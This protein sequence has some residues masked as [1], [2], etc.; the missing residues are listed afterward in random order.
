VVRRG[1]YTVAQWLE[2]CVE[3]RGNLR[4]NTRRV[5][6]SHV[7]Q[8]LRRVFDGML[9]KEL[10]VA[11]VERAFARLLGEGMTAATARR[12]FST[13]R[14][15]LNAAVREGLIPR[16][17]AR[18]VKLPRAHQGVLRGHLTRSRGQMRMEAM[19]IVPWHPA[20]RTRASRPAG[21]LTTRI[22]GSLGRNGRG[23]P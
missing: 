17:P 16:S 14:T 21:R 6:K 13:L 3:T 15:A 10:D 12:V 20:C 22:S 19:P 4:H 2:A 7:R 11:R 23:S 1:L 5:Y 8:H 9:L 18:Y